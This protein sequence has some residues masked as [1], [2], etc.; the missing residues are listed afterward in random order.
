M[1]A[2]ASLILEVQ[3]NTEA[4][5]HHGVVLTS[6]GAVELLKRGAGNFVR[7]FASRAAISSGR[8]HGRIRLALWCAAVWGVVLSTV[9]NPGPHFDR[10]SSG[11]RFNTVGLRAL[12]DVERFPLLLVLGA[13]AR[14]RAL[15][16]ESNFAAT[17]FLDHV[18]LIPRFGGRTATSTR[19]QL[20]CTRGHGSERNSLL[21][22]RW[23]N[24]ELAPAA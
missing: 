6:A 14:H 22:R 18:M 16:V 21:N 24:R 20:R 2:A 11:P 4:T 23:S 13:M 1:R 9:R 5:A 17:V 19:R 10:E 15:R 12:R 3:R 8:V 7:G